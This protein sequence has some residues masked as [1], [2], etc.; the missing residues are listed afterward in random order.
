MFHTAHAALIRAAAYPQ[1]LRL[2]A[3][4]DLTVDRPEA[5]LKWLREVWALPEFAAAVGQAA[6]HLTAQITRA[7]AREPMTMRRLRRVVE[8]TVRYLLR[9]TTRA[10]PFGRLAGVAPVEFGPRAV[11]RWGER[12]H[13]AT[14][15]DDRFI[16]EY[17]AVAERDLETLRTVAVVTNVLGYRR[18]GVWVLPCARGEGNRVWDVEI[19]LTGPVRVAVETAS[20]PIAFRELAAKVADEQATETAAAERLLGALVNAGVLL[21]A[22]RPPMTVPDPAAH[23]ARHIDLPDPGDRIAVDMRVDCSVTLPPAVV[24]E[25]QEAASALVA[26]A[27]RLPGWAAYHR[28]FIERWGPGAA[29][30]LRDVLRVLG[31]P[32]GY[33]GSSRRD[34]AG[35]TA[36]D[37]LLAELAQRS[38]LDGCAEVVLDDDLIASLRGEDDRPPLPHTELRFTLAA[39]TPQDPE[40]DTSHIWQATAT[41]TSSSAHSRTSGYISLGERSPGQNTRPR[42]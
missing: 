42:A 26:V 31:F 38:A 3:W 23:L 19:D 18:G 10:T 2:P 1:D 34:S 12:H 4:P 6:P 33:R 13:E 25:A 8:A 32:A 40:Q 30:P 15:P 41:S 9:W 7:L 27:P 5:W 14:R 28:A 36:R 16:A 29:V 11:V 22:V 20:A 21:S 35:F 24:G 17:T 39:A 37:A